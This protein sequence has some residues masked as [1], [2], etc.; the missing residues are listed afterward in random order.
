MFSPGAVDLL[1][2]R[3]VA[4]ERPGTIGWEARVIAARGDLLQT[5]D[6]LLQG[7]HGQHHIVLLLQIV[8]ASRI[9][10]FSQC[11]ALP[12]CPINDHDNL[13]Y[14]LFVCFSSRFDCCILSFTSESLCHSHIAFSTS[15]SLSLSLSTY[16]GFFLSSS[17][18]FQ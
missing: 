18:C 16:A 14:T 17:P 6:V 1:D 3:Q 9:V 11:W 4:R 2:A 15:L 5:W 7:Q 8:H 13:N 10:L 12:W